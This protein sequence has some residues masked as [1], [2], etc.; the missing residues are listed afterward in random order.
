VE[1]ITVEG[2]NPL[3]GSVRIN[4][5][6]NATLPIMAASLLTSEPVVIEGVPDLV[7]VKIMLRILEA[8]GAEVTHQKT[9]ETLHIQVPNLKRST[10]AHELVSKMRASFLV[11]GPLLART[12]KACI[13]LPG[14]CAIGVRPIDLHWKG[15]KA[16][17][18][19]FT[20]GNGFMEGNTSGLKGKRIYLD[21]PSVGATENIMM[22]ASL[23]SGETIIENASVEPEVVDVAKFLVALGGQIEGAGTPTIRIEGKESLGGGKHK[24]IPDRIETGT[25]MIAAALCNG[26]VELENVCPHHLNSL[27]AKLTEAEVGVEIKSDDRIIIDSQARPRAVDIKTMPYPGFPTDLQPQ[28]T[29]FLALS[30]GVGMITET[31]F[32]NRFHHVQEL[33]RMGAEI[34]IEGRKLIMHG[35]ERLQGNE[36]R[37][38][39]LRAAAALVIAGLVASGRTDISGISHLDRGYY[40]FDG[41]LKSLGAEIY[42]TS[43]ASDQKQAL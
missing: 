21:Y 12:G 1:Q 26:K 6:K 41:K 8:L 15:L 3:A 34:K 9:K 11:M 25:F 37:A 31:V 38:K 40:D 5:A 27:V 39:D 33:V 10:V 24:V 4:G 30:K 14:G 16:M 36:V 28:F 42:R 17:G 7:D 20:V 22:A 19:E 13:S 35:K 2:G 23:A 43:R 18:A 29:A 32:E